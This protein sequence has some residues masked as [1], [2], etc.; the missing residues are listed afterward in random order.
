M[1]YNEIS[2]LPSLR[3]LKIKE[4]QLRCAISRASVYRL[5][6]EGKFPRQVRLSSRAIGFYEHEVNEWIES[7]HRAE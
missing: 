7:R 2:S 5:I 1:S 3:L 6:S 4:V